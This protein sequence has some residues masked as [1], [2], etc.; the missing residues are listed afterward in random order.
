MICAQ[1]YPSELDEAVGRLLVWAGNVGIA[2]PGRQ[3][4]Y[5][6]LR[7]SPHPRHATAALLDSVQQ[8]L[9]VCK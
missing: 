7:D 5:E 9:D 1:K 8:M 4:L 3:S 6:T 2:K